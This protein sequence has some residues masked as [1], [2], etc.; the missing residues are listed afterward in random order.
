MFAGDQAW[1]TDK[2]S[3]PKRFADE[4]LEQAGSKL[5][6]FAGYAPDHPELEQLRQQHQQLCQENAARRKSAMALTFLKADKY[7]GGDAD[8][9]MAFARKLVPKTHEGAEVLR[10]TIFTEDWK[11]ETVTEWTDTTHSALRTRTTRT[12]MFCVA[13]Q[14][15]EGV[16]RDF[17]YLNQNRTSGGGWGNT[18]GHLAKYRAPMLKENVA[19]DGPEEE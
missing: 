12:L 11:E 8:E 15:K 9:L 16:F 14:D 18:Y 2:N 1:K 3:Q 4:L 13:F 6:D 5:D 17:G 10:L 7:K 19:K